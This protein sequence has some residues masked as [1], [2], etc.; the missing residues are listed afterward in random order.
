MKFLFLLFGLALSSSLAASATPSVQVH[1]QV[2]P[3][4]RAFTCRYVFSVLARPAVATGWN[5]PAIGASSAYL[6]R[7]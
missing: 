6:S 4:T 2:E 5:K 7:A 3:T 1:L